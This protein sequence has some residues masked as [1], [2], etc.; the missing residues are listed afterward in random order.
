MATASQSTLEGTMRVLAAS[1]YA[2]A[3]IKVGS[4]YPHSTLKGTLSC[5]S[6]SSMRPT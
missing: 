2:V 5:S 4:E 3:I 1:A 6:Y